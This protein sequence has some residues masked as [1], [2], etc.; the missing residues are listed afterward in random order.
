MD[1]HVLWILKMKEGAM[2]HPVHRFCCP[3]VWCFSHGKAVLYADGLKVVLPI[4]LSDINNSYKFIVS[5]LNNLSIW[6]QAT[7]LQ[8]NFN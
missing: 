7:G 2:A 3:C 5:D 1:G 6:S 8:F 4:S